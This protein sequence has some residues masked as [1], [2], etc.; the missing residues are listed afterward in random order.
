M[1]AITIALHHHEINNHPERISQLIPYI[2]HDNLIWDKINFPA[3]G[4][5]WK[6][7]Q[8]NNQNIAFNICSVP[9]Q[10]KQ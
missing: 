10:K 8:R 6:R 3:E 9:F 7:F 2:R 1:Y 4:K 5:D